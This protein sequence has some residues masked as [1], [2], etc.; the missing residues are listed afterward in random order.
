MNPIQLDSIQTSIFNQIELISNLITNQSSH[1]S[2]T[3]SELI[4]YNFCIGLII[5]QIDCFILERFLIVDQ[6][7]AQSETFFECDPIGLNLNR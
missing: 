3:I 5:N 6:S 2:P 4:Y 1:N 7:Y